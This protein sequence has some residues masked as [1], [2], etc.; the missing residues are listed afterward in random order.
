M[1]SSS[2]LTE[3]LYD[4]ETV[5]RLVDRELDELRDELPPPIPAG[6]SLAV[7]LSLMQRT[8]AGTLQVLATLQESRAALQDITLREIQECADKLREV[9]A[10]TQIAASRILDGL[11]RAHALVDQLDRV[12]PPEHIGAATPDVLSV[13]TRLRDELFAI[14]GSLQFQ[15]ITSQQLGHVS[16]MLGDAERRVHAMASLLEGGGAEAAAIVA[17]P[18][19]T[20]AESASTVRAFERQ[21]VADAVFRDETTRRTTH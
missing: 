1:S 10:T 21:A 14:M 16:K 17:E 5:L 4:S 8:N 9:A 6:H 7:L 18:A 20:F 3:I 15:D 19:P 2:R 12:H 11:E 13:R